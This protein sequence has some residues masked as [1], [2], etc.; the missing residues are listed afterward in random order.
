[1][2]RLPLQQNDKKKMTPQV[3]WPILKL[4]PARVL[5][6]LLRARKLNSCS[7]ESS[8]KVSLDNSC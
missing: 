5:N 3:P 6:L 1:M 4:K 7:G 8:D 2:S